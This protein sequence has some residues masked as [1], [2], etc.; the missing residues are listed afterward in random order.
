MCVEGVG[1]GDGV[2]TGFVFDVHL[3]LFHPSHCFVPNAAL[4]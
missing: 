2:V 4:F 1:G 3:F